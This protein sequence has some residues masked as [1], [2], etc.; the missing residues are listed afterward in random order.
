M[1]FKNKHSNKPNI[2]MEINIEDTPIQQVDTTKFFGLLIDSNLSWNSP[3]NMFQD[4]L[5]VQRYY[6]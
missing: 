5:Q 6:S 1:I 4:R 2:N 3:L